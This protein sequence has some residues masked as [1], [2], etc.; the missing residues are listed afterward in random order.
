MRQQRKK[1][2]VVY[3]L[4]QRDCDFDRERQYQREHYQW[5]RATTASDMRN[6]LANAQKEWTTLTDKI[7]LNDLSNLFN[8]LSNFE[9][10]VDGLR[11]GLE[12]LSYRA[13]CHGLSEWY[14][15]V[16]DDALWSLRGEFEEVEHDVGQLVDQGWCDDGYEDQVQEEIEDNLMPKLEEAMSEFIEDHQRSSKWILEQTTHRPQLCSSGGAQ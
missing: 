1:A 4:P 10:V 7:V 11:S 2:E 8:L 16:Y 6:V 12:N 13:T 15:E 3:L 5:T 14:D 9:S